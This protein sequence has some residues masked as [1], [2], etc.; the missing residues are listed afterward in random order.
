[1]ESPNTFR[2]AC[3]HAGAAA[4]AVNPWAP[5][6]LFHGKLSRRAFAFIDD[7]SVPFAAVEPLRFGNR[8]RTYHKIPGSALNNCADGPPKWFGVSLKPGI[9]A[10]DPIDGHE[11]TQYASAIRRTLRQNLFW[12]FAYNVVG[13]PLAAFG[14][15]SP[16][17]AGS[18]MALSS[19]SV[20]ANALTLKR[21]KP[22]GAVR[23]RLSGTSAGAPS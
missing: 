23:S 4:T 14:L 17:V 15:L 12:A 22:A 10:L 18:A 16:M 8:C 9:P 13:I 11:I 3:C 6:A 2:L 7:L 1:V 21:W 19:V 20:M 5:Y